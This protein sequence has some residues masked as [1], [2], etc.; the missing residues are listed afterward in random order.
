MSESSVFSPQSSV[1]D[2]QSSTGSRRV[3]DGRRRPT[4][5]SKARLVVGSPRQG[6]RHRATLRVL[7]YDMVVES[8]RAI[9]S[10]SWPRRDD[11]H[12][13]VGRPTQGPFYTK[14]RVCRDPGGRH[15]SSRAGTDVCKSSLLLQ[16]HLAIGTDRIA[17]R[18]GLTPASAT[19]DVVLSRS[20]GTV[21]LRR[22][23]ELASVGVGSPGI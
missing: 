4:E 12:T 13:S 21:V 23:G 15:A 10:Y 17:L 16:C 2:L 7:V 20:C 11:L 22:H 19:V 9:D 3:R 8:I 1:V 6:R 5:G 14:G 18:L